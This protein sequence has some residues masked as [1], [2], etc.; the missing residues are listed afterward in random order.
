[1]RH[2]QPPKIPL[3]AVLSMSKRAS[4]RALGAQDEALFAAVRSNDDQE[5]AALL[6]AGANTNV[7]DQDGMT[8]AM[9]ALL[10]GNRESLGV[11]MAAGL[12]HSVKDNHG[13]SIF[14]YF[15]QFASLSNERM[16]N[17]SCVIASLAFEDALTQEKIVGDA[18]TGR[19]AKPA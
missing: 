8:P 4:V 3:A 11:L 6:K 10:R 12:D 7:Q 16:A 17:T 9:W 18:R 19:F 5:V 1:M 15:P 14:D 2:F 13:Q